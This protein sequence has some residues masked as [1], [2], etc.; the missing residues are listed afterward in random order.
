[1]RRVKSFAEFARQVTYFV[2]VAAD[3][4]ADFVLL[5]ELFTVQLLSAT[6]TLSP[7]EGMRKLSDYT[8]RLDTL[9]GK[10]ALRH[11]VTIIGG[12]HPTKIGKELRN[13][14]TIYLP[15]G[16]RVRQPKLHITPNERHWWGITGGSTL[17]TV[18]TPVARIGVLICYDAEFPEAARHLADLGAEITFV[19][20]CTDNRQ[21]Y[22]RVRHCAAARAIENQVYVA[23]AGNIG[24]L[25]DVPNMDSQYGQ[26]AVLTP[27]DFA[28]ARD[29]I[30]AEADA[31]VET[32]LICDVDLD[33]LQKAHSTGT[34]TPRLDRRPDLFK[35]IATVG[36][37]EPPVSLRE[38]DGPLGEQPQ[39]DS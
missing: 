26:A 11:G 38:G 15:D 29:G 3:N 35:V 27:S 25:P 18:D 32:V 17:Q 23:L 20:F 21:G 5:P 28:F 22:L 33:E 30:A 31:N 14:A 24:N 16:R 36:N 8:G 4:D 34:V 9:L 39:R 12:G 6:N 2:D 7:Q 1:M 13:I 10:L 37:N 19:P